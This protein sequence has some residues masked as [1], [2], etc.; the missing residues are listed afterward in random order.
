MQAVEDAK[1]APTR[2]ASE[3]I[4]RAEA[5]A[6]EARAK[7]ALAAAE[8]SRLPQRTTEAA[9]QQLETARNTIVAAPEKVAENAK[10]VFKETEA[11]VE[12]LVRRMP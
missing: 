7:A 6:E 11:K 4:A 1:V 9:A 10:S 8:A 2:L 3:V 12:G 5:A